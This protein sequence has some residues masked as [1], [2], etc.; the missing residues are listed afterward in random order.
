MRVDVCT[1]DI[2]PGHGAAVA[3]G[4]LDLEDHSLAE[5]QLAERLLGLGAV[6]LLG[7][8]GIDFGHADL[9]LALGVGQAGEGVAVV[10]ADNL[11]VDVSSQGQRGGEGE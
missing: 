7:F 3:V 1:A 5:H 8:G 11:A 2:G 9:D 6:G 4:V 10:H